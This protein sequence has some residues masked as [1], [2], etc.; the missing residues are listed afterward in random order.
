MSD[1]RAGTEK[2]VLDPVD[3]FGEIVFGLV[4]VLTFTCSLSVA[5]SDRA[6][7][8]DMIV[9]AL[10][11]NLAW[12]I[13][14]AAFYLIAVLAERGRGARLLRSVR[15]AS[16]P[17]AGRAVIADSLPDVVASA[18]SAEQLE[19]VRASIASRP[20]P[21]PVK[22]SRRDLAGACAVFLLVFL[23]TFPVVL[24]FFFFGDEVRTAV[25]VSNGIAIA[26]LFGVA[27][28]LAQ[29][30]GLRPV[31]TGAAMV[32]IGAALVAIAIALGG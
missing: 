10:G 23:S 11:C 9:G 22:F 12:G 2:R 17:E 32:G 5:E 3:R 25:R 24:P 28:K 20:L 7:V 29:H 30:A 31:R 15:E 21:A 13:I 8:R 26:L 19:A 18:L 4:M 14:D 16:V 1:L 27:Y 6:E